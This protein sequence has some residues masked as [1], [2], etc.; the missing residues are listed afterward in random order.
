MSF[1]IYLQ[2]VLSFTGETLANVSKATLEAAQDAYYHSGNSRECGQGRRET[3]DWL[4]SF[5]K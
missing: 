4:A 1:D 5:F 3:M 2:R